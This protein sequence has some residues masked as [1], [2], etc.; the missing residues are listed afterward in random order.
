MRDRTRIAKTHSQARNSKRSDRDR[1]K[2]EW[3]R[4]SNKQRCTW[5]ATAPSLDLDLWNFNIDEFKDTAKL[6]AITLG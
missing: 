1:G 3:I 2:P 6:F 4:I 5:R